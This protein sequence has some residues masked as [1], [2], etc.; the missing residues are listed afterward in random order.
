MVL[1]MRR[2]VLLVIATAA[3]GRIGFDPSGAGATG[4]P[5]LA[6][7]MRTDAT[8]VVAV[9]DPSACAAAGG[10]CLRDTCVIDCTGFGDCANVTCP[11][12]ANC[13]ITCGY[14]GCANVQ[15]GD[16]PRC[17]IHCEQTNGC[18]NVDCDRESMCI[19]ECMAIDRCTGWVNC[20]VAA[21]CSV[22]CG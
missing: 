7:A 5:Q 15:C 9:C 2:G 4:D 11:P 6:D 18:T 22:T 17:V 12:G 8:P 21:Q 1:G 10:S 13:D 14:M 16:A 20:A 19:V 3:C